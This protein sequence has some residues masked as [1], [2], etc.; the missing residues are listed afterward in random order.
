MKKHN[1]KSKIELVKAKQFIL[2]VKTKFAKAY[3]TLLAK[4]RVF[5]VKKQYN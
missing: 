2:K 5:E 1:F 4:K 3:L